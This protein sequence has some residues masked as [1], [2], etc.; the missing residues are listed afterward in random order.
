VVVVDQALEVGDRFEKLD[1]EF[2]LGGATPSDVLRRT[3]VPRS[4]VLLLK[5][6]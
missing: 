2:I 5:E 1:V 4:N 6:S 3:G